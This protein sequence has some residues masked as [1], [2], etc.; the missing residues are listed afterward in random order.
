[1]TI[2]LQTATTAAALADEIGKLDA[3]KKQIEEKLS[4]AKAAFKAMG[5]ERIE[6][7]S[8]RIEHGLSERA[9]LDTAA[10]KKEMGDKWYNAHCKVSVVSTVYI[11]PKS[12]SIIVI[13]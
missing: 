9:N 5:V 1:M 13:E 3:I 12:A 6:G 10:V 4:A 7:A 11:K 2:P 8:Y